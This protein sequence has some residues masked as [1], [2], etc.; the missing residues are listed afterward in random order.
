MNQVSMFFEHRYITVLLNIFVFFLIDVFDF[1]TISSLMSEA[2][3]SMRAKSFWTHLCCTIA[4][5]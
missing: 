3:A 1:S 2:H 4:L 5:I